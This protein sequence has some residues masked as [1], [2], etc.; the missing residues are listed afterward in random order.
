MMIYTWHERIHTGIL[1]ICFLIL[2]TRSYILIT[3]PF[4][5]GVGRFLVQVSFVVQESFE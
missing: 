1:C 4:L 2:C 5:S 3:A